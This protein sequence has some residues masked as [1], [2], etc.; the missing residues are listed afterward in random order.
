MVHIS[1]QIFNLLWSYLI[2]TLEWVVEGLS[3]STSDYMSPYMHKPALCCF[4][5]IMIFKLICSN[6][7]RTF[8]SRSFVFCIWMGY[9]GKSANYFCSCWKIILL[10]HKVGLC[11]HGHNYYSQHMGRNLRYAM[12]HLPTIPGGRGAVYLSLHHYIFLWDIY[13]MVTLRLKILLRWHNDPYCLQCIKE[14]HEHAHLVM[15]TA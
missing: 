1:L 11:L 14:I 3:C 2:R 13:V 8:H 9:N 12:H 7:V 10:R 4:F 6:V 15:S 5:W